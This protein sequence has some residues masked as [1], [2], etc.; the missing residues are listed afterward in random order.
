MNDIDKGIAPAHRQVFTCARV[1][2]VHMK[3]E[4]LNKR[5]PNC[6]QYV[7]KVRPSNTCRIKYYD[8]GQ[9]SVTLKVKQQE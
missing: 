6:P 3:L 9:F 1:Y 5:N 8:K 2:P 7:R 4:K